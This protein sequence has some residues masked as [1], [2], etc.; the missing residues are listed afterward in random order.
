MAT[1]TRSIPTA[2]TIGSDRSNPIHQ[3]FRALQIGFIVAPILA[4]LDKFVGLLTDWTQYLWPPFADLLGL[5]PAT[6]MGVVGVVEIAAGIT[7]AVKPRFGGYLVAG[8]LA[9]II[10]NLILIGSFWDVALRDLGLAIGAF[11]L[12]RLASAGGPR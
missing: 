9:G 10:L 12:A 3:A 11:A 4:G 7:V 2:D 8:W 6:F 5:T 1:N